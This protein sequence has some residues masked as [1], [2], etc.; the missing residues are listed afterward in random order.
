MTGYKFVAV[1]N[2]KVEVG[3]VMNALGHMSVALAK[4]Y[5]DQEGLGVINYEDAS[6][7]P[8]MAPKHPYI[9]LRA[10]NSNKIRT[11]RNAAIEKGIHSVSFTSAMTE[12]LFEDQ[13]ERS[14]GI[15][16]EELEYYGICMFGK[17]EDFEGLTDKFQL[18]N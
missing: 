15:S 2:K 9:I 12:G 1:L 3:K 14:K 7:S 5:A 17:V 16:E 8:H 18:W 10:K 4:T 11:L 6:G 13:V